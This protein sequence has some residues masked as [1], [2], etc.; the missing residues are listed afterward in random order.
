M[1]KDDKVYLLHIIDA[2]GLIEEYLQGVE[3]SVFLKK[4]LIQDGVIR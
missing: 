1:K 4:N 3:K 2:I